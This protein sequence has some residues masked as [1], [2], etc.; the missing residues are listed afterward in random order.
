MNPNCLKCKH[1]FITFDQY[2]PK[3]CRIYKIKSTTMPS[4]IVKR[5]NNGV[6]CIGFEEKKKNNS[7]D[8]KKKDLNDPKLW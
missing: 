5:A 1:Y 2:A 8:S 3:G 4:Q 6:D 7:T